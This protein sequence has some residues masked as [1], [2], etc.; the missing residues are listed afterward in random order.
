MVKITDFS[1]IARMPNEPGALHKAAEITK[2]YNLLAKDLMNSV[3][4]DGKNAKEERKE[5]HK[6]ISK[7]KDELSKNEKKIL[8]YGGHG[9]IST[10]CNDK[11]EIY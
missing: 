2:K 6:L 9:A 3:N 8:I 7:L 11:L 4:V 5:L 10:V 1:F